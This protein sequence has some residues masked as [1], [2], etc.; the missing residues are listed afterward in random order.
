MPRRC[1]LYEVRDL[2]LMMKV[3]E[4]GG[5][6]GVTLAELSESFGLKEDEARSL[7]MRCAWMKKYGIFSY[8][9]PTKMWT[10]SQ[11]GERVVAAKIKATAAKAIDTVP[12][13]SMV[14]VMAHV[15]SRYRLGDPMLA[16]MLR[17]EFMFGTSPKSTI[18][19]GGT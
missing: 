3:A 18:W 10:L 4:E 6:S 17:R 1:N 12:D 2:E 8:D 19:Q 9:Q 15:T 7:V 11:G 16:I 5:A 13:D 14:D